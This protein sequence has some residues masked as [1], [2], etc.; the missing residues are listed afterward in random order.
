VTI[1]ATLCATIMCCPEPVVPNVLYAIISPISDYQKEHCYLQLGCH[2]DANLG[3]YCYS[4]LQ[5]LKPLEGHLHSTKVASLPDR[6]PS[7]QCNRI[8]RAAY[9]RS[10]EQDC[11]VNNLIDTNSKA[12]KYNHEIENTGPRMLAG[13]RCFI[14]GWSRSSNTRYTQ[15]SCIPNLPVRDLLRDSTLS[16]FTSEEEKQKLKTYDSIPKWIF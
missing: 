4:P 7:V 12:K 13:R 8:T 15:N 9:L 1:W 14:V 11:S 3:T 10:S 16:T 2:F 6:P 5:K